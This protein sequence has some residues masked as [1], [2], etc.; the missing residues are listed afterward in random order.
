[1]YIYIYTHVYL[2]THKFEPHDG[3]EVHPGERPQH[4]LGLNMNKY[5]VFCF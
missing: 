1:M 2:H 3:D 5:V 4:L